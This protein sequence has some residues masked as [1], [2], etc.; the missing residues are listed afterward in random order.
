MPAP[1]I[2][3]H[4]SININL[5]ST[6]QHPRPMPI[7]A[8]SQ[9]IACSSPRAARSPAACTSHNLS[10]ST[11][12]RCSSCSTNNSNINTQPLDRTITSS[13][14][15]VLIRPFLIWYIISSNWLQ[16][17]GSSNLNKIHPSYHNL[18]A[19]FLST[20]AN[21]FPVCRTLRSS[22]QDL[23]IMEQVCWGEACE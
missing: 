12:L 2:L 3:L 11:A 16:Q 6:I 7:Q 21:C 17:L 19:R 10:S 5:I 22:K 4:S 20:M 15:V 23:S 9:A 14:R 13:N 1:R 18:I 8:S